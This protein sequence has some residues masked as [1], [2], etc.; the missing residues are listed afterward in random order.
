MSDADDTRIVEQRMRAHYDRQVLSPERLEALLRVSGPMR[1]E[2]PRSGGS[3]RHA[4]ALF[5]APR[6]R[7]RHPRLGSLYGGRG[8]RLAMLAALLIVVAV[9]MRLDGSASE[10]TARTLRDAAMNHST[11]FEPEFRG[12]T[13]AALDADMRLLPFSLSVPKRIADEEVEVIGSRYC[14]LAGRLAAHLKLR[15]RDGGRPVSLFV[16]SLAPELAAMAG[17]GGDIDGVEVDLWQEGG[18]FYAFAR[19]H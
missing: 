11:R 17:E 16:A 13:V 15:E 14:S 10:R 2:E 6:S 4:L 1:Q 19:H 18:L 5:D 3:L 8:S 7:I 12:N 9:T